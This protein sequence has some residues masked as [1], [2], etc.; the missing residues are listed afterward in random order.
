MKKLLVLLSPVLLSGCFICHKTAYQEEVVEVVEQEIVEQY[1]PVEQEKIISRHSIPEAANFEFDSKEIRPD[2][3][4]LDVLEADIAAH[5]EATIL[6][7]GHTDNVG[8]EQYNKEL[9]YARAMSV[10]KVLAQKGYPNQ[11]R[12]YGAGYS[13][14]IASNDTAEGRAQNRR[15]DVVLVSE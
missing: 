15:V 3:N 2:M 4:K 9:S 6:V 14:P 10:A 5:P 8:T 12:V 13:S 7:E 1:L 11:I